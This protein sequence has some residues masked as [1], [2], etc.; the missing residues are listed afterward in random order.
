MPSERWRTCSEIFDAALACPKHERAAFLDQRCAGDPA[1]RRQ[2]EVMLKH[3][4]RAGVFLDLPAFEIAPELLLDDADA[5]I[6]QH[7]GHYRIESVLGLGGMGVV[8]LAQDEKLG[9]KVA[10]KLLPQSLVTNEVRLERLKRE[11]RTASALNHPNIVTIHEIGEVDGVHYI[12]TEYIEGPTLRAR[13]EQGPIPPNEGLKVAEQIASAL[14][15]AHGAGIV[16]CDIKP[17]NIMLRPDGLV[18]VLDFG[19]AKFTQQENRSAG[20]EGTKRYMSPEQARGEEL[21]A[22]SDIWSLGV[23]LRETM[24]APVPAQLERVIDRAVS[25]DPEARYASATDLRADLQRVQRR[26]E[27]RPRWRFAAVAVVGLVMV[28]VAYVKFFSATPPLEEK[29]IAVLPF[30]DLSPAGDQQYFCD[31]IQEEILTRLARVADLK[32]ISRTST[33][34]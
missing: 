24:A 15:V 22:R 20:V 25:D 8:Y 11:A 4:A 2:V 17:E 28:V 6:G 31:G 1:L 19:I 32:V 18:K 9:R 5:L 16:H 13:I 29:S 33:E 7:L 30:T 10:L 14:C 27:A 23:T 3:H 21:D 26:L 12:A 34:R